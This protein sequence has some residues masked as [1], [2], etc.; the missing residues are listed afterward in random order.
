MK[1]Y[2]FPQKRKNLGLFRTDVPIRFHVLCT[3]AAGAAIEK[4]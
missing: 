3:L 2:F 1:Q 4:S